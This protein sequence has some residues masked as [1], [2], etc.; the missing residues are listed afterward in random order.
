LKQIIDTNGDYTWCPTRQ[1]QKHLSPEIPYRL[2][3]TLMG[4]PI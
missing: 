4:H 1:M 2:G 3:W